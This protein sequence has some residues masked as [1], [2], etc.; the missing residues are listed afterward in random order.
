MGRVSQRVVVLNAFNILKYDIK[1]QL[2]YKLKGLRTVEREWSYMLKVSDLK[3]NAIFPVGFLATL[4]TE[5]THCGSELEITETLT[6]I[7]CV[8]LGCIE[9]GVQRML[10]L[11]KDLGVKNM[12]EAQCR[13]FLIKFKTTNPYAILLYEPSEDGALFENC[14]MDF[15]YGIYAKLNAVRE[16]FLWEYVKIGNLYGISDISRNLLKNFVS[17]D[18][19]YKDLYYGG[20]EWVQELIGLE[21]DSIVSIKAIDVYN[22]LIEYEHEL[23]SGID[24]V[25]LKTI[26][27]PSLTVSIVGSVGKPFKSKIDFIQK[28]VAIVEGKVNLIVLDS[29]T[30][31]C[32]FLIWSKEGNVTSK[33]NKAIEY[34]IPIYSGIEFA[35]YLKSRCV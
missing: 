17:I 20:V 10:H 26:D 32:D 13:A 2:K 23:R 6:V 27:T 15:S 16:M 22:T 8:N 14:S 35:E 1:V 29:L 4:P 5:C 9:K 25:L 24:G 33:V 12:G 19:F 21:L 28:M 30:A 3:S 34:K 7:Q 18:G 11:L 31:D